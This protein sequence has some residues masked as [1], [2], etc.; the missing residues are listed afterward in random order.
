MNLG[1][2]PIA[3]RRAAGSFGAQYGVV[4]LIE[5]AKPSIFVEKPGIC[6]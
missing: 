6:W 1:R 5:G 4:E 2:R 3:A